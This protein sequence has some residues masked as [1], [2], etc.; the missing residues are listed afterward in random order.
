MDAFAHT[1]YKHKIDRELLERLS[2]AILVLKLHAQNIARVE[3]L[4]LIDVN[5]ARQNTADLLGDL[6]EGVRFLDSGTG[7]R[8]MFDGTTQLALSGLVDRFVRINPA[9]VQELQKLKG[10]LV[11]GMNLKP[12]DFKRLDGI[13]RLLEEEADEATRALYSF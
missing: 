8:A 11:R 12:R 10:R 13:Q 2:E 9:D 6:A 1:S 5:T 3:G 4:R 7:S